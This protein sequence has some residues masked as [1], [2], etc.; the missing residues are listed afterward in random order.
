MLA[1]P[2][3][4]SRHMEQYAFSRSVNRPLLTLTVGDIPR[5]TGTTILR[6]L[7]G[8][9][10]MTPEIIPVVGRIRELAVM[11]TKSLAPSAY[12]VE[13]LP[14]MKYLPNRIAKWK[15]D[16]IRHAREYTAMLER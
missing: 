12:L 11:I 3:N 14:A 5:F 16:G 2:Q 8:W 15:R 1:D 7:Y 10:P 13:M 9:P 4:W 6:S